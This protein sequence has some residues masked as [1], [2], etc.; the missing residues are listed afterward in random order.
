MI[1]TINVKETPQWR[2]FYWPISLSSEQERRWWWWQS[3]TPQSSSPVGGGGAGTPGNA[4][5]TTLGSQ[6]AP[7]ATSASSSW[8]TRP[9]M[10]GLEISISPQLLDWAWPGEACGGWRWGWRMCWGRWQCP[11][12]WNLL[13]SNKWLPPLLPSTPV[14]APNYQPRRSLGRAEP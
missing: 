10:V 11:A 1:L 3:W 8:D 7:R 6:V 13:T 9:L 14:P 2:P 12:K 5:T 4:L